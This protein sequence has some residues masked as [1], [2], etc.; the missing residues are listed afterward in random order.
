[1]CNYIWPYSII[2]Q[3]LDAIVANITANILD[4]KIEAMTPFESQLIAFLYLT[5]QMK[6][7]LQ[8]SPSNSYKFRTRRW[9]I[10]VICFVLVWWP[11]QGIFVVVWASRGAE[12]VISDNLMVLGIFGWMHR[13]PCK[14]QS[15]RR[16]GAVYTGEW[17]NNVTWH[18]VNWKHGIIWVRHLN[19]CEVPWGLSVEQ[20]HAIAND[21]FFGELIDVWLESRCVFLIL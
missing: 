4:F 11:K 1:M 10:C 5:L 13:S 12:G 16:T 20:S 21:L 2:L 18:C 3:Y 15:S 8:L 19:T 17:L 7:E 14:H 6:K 9:G